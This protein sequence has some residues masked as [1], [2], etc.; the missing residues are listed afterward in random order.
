MC[1]RDEYRNP[2]LGT[3][4][5]VVGSDRR[6]VM[7]RREGGHESGTWTFPGGFVEYWEDPADTAV[8]ETFEEIGVKVG[9]PTFLT[10][11]TEMFRELDLHTVTLWFAAPLVEGTPRQCEPVLTRVGWFKLRKMPVPLFEPFQHVD[12]DALRRGLDVVGRS[13]RR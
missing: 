3:M 11:T 9:P 2:K 5:M 10:Q 13:A 1:V 6:I 4:V 8:R 7:G 12:F